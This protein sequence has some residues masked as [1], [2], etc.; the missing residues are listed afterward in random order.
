MTGKPVR[1]KLYLEN[2]GKRFSL[3]FDCAKCEMAIVED[4]P[5]SR[6]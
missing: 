6:K 5:L 4:T 2:N 1:N 3:V